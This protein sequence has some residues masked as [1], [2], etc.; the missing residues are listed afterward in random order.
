MQPDEAYFTRKPLFYSFFL[1]SLQHRDEGLPSYSYGHTRPIKTT[2]T[3][4]HE[5]ITT[6]HLGTAHN[7]KQQRTAERT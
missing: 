4:Q 2:Y 1:V 6:H 3:Q 7:D 5:K